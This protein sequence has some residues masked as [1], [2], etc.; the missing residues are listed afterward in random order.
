MKKFIVLFVAFIATTFFSFGEEQKELEVPN[1][2]EPMRM[3][4]VLTQQDFM[5]E[6]EIEKLEAKLMEFSDSA[7]NQIVVVVVDGLNG[8]TPNEFA[9]SLGEKWGVGQKKLDNGV[10]VLL[11]LGGGEGK[12][13]YYISPG[14]GLEGALPDLRIKRI[15]EKE[16]LPYL[17]LGKYYQALDKTTNAII[18]YA[19][20]EYSN[21]DLA[22]SKEGNKDM[23]GLYIFLGILG[24][25]IFFG[26]K[27]KNKR[28]DDKDIKK[29]TDGEGE[30]GNEEEGENKG[31]GLSKAAATAGTAAGAAYL[32]S[33]MGKNKEEKSKDDEEEPK[34]FG[35]GS[36][37]G[38]G[39]KW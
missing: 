4:N 20:G 8:L 12:R 9:T 38:A 21:E 24:V 23:T 32:G 37:G 27:N 39:G 16:L 28:K 35:G 30:E 22:K 7:S 29:L 1:R 14:Y 34:N 26:V 18:G 3:V 6:A 10:I 11:S 5:T 13:D 25:L 15:E 2:P 19:K 31:D 36:F 17:K 33:K